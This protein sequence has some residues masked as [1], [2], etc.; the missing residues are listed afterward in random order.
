MKNLTS[1]LLLLL[2]ICLEKFWILASSYHLHL[3]K[4]HEKLRCQ[5]GSFC[6]SEFGRHCSNPPIPG[7]LSAF[8][9]T[10]MVRHSCLQLYPKAGAPTSFSADPLM[11]KQAGNSAASQI[12]GVIEGVTLGC[13]SLSVTSGSPCPH[14]SSSPQKDG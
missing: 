12:L 5:P 8:M 9:L 3:V 4:Q 1:D 7:C 14:V 11:A 6:L 13:V 10:G 2:R